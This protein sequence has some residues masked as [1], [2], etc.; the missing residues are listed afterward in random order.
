M[1]VECL[2]PQREASA[3]AKKQDFTNFAAAVAKAKTLWPLDPIVKVARESI[4]AFSQKS[5]ELE[6]LEVLDGLV[7]T[8]YNNDQF[9]PLNAM[10]MTSAED[11]GAIV[12]T[13]RDPDKHTLFSVGDST[14]ELV[15]TSA[16]GHNDA[17]KI[18]S[19]V[20][21][22]IE[23]PLNKGYQDFSHACVATSHLDD[24]VASYNN[25][26]AQAE[27]ILAVDVDFVHA[28]RLLGEVLNF[29][30][31]FSDMIKLPP[32]S[33]ADIFDQRSAIA[34]ELVNAIRDATVT[35]TTT[36]WTALVGK[37]L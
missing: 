10:T 9:V 23:H 33:V 34:T 31:T 24:A 15:K 7:M 5:C 30:A 3:R 8:C 1:I 21:M 36:E 35:A 28:K 37:G 4:E 16:I 13:K 18:L 26:K 14:I 29:D 25:H 6:K 22:H 11:L 32:K 20:A 19:F 2:D 17:S 27:D 12:L